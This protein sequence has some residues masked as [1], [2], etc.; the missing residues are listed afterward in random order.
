MNKTMIE[1]DQKGKIFGICLIVC[2][3]SI[4]AG[5]II[6]YQMGMAHAEF[7]LQDYDKI[8]YEEIEQLT[9][10]NKSLIQS[11][12]YWQIEIDSMVPV[13]EWRLAEDD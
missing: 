2:I 12:T 11:M 7:W 6:G 4:S 10:W 1:I 5:L 3:L 9:K 13:L 8:N